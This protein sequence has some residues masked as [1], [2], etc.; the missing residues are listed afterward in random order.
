MLISRHQEGFGKYYRDQPALNVND[1][2][3]DFLSNN[4]NSA[5]FQ[6]K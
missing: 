3:I 2:I 1:E 4:N 5:S 6:S